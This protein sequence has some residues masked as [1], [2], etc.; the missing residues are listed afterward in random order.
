M[1]NKWILLAALSLSPLALAATST[2]TFGD[3]R[4][5]VGIEAGM[6]F[7]TVR[8][9]SDVTPSNRTGLAAGVNVEIPV[10]AYFSIQPEA[11]FVQR[12]ADLATVGN[13]RFTASYNSLEF[14]VLAK[15]KIPGSVSPFLAAG[16]VG[17]WNISRSVEA[18]GPGGGAALAFNPR[19][20][21]FG[22]GLAA[23][24]DIGPFF[25]TVRYTV[26]I[27]DLDENS[28]D[29]RSRGVHALA[30]LRF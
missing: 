23:G 6:T 2:D 14:P 11:L 24:L 16:P 8:A 5:R 30:G 4:T 27:T 28:A 10:T 26:G 3:E 9:P 1:K 22:V 21:D 19:T 7:S 18:A 29:W 15:L 13:T 20:F 17:I 25:A 12:G